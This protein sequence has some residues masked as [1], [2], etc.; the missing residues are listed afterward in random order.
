MIQYAV[1][2]GNALRT[3]EPEKLREHIRKYKSILPE[4]D[5]LLKMDD[6]FTLGMIAKMVMNRT[7]MT[8]EDRKRAKA[9]LDEM[10]WSEEIIYDAGEASARVD[11][12]KRK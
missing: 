4:A 3:F 11:R 8:N 10:G 7:D 5:E 9:I 6:R 1:D 2:L 12:R